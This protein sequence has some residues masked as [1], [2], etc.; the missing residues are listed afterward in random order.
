[1]NRI[2]DKIIEIEKFLKE[3][4]VSIPKSLEDY[5]NDFKLRAIGER[6]FEKI[7]EAMS[8]LSF[9]IIKEKKLKQPEE[10][11]NVFDDSLVL[12][13]RKED[14]IVSLE[15]FSDPNFLPTRDQIIKAFPDW[16]Q[17]FEFCFNKENPTFEFLNNEYLESLTEYFIDKN[18]SFFN[19]SNR[20]YH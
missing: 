8:D 10:E 14:Q 16:H 9:L 4:E 19:N 12:P 17:W 15:K 5:K 3:L 7:V 1:M 2:R 20:Y 6:Y 13:E 11:E 18:K